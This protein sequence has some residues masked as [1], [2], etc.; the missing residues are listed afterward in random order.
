MQTVMTKSR[1]CWFSI[2]SK[3]RNLG[4]TKLSEISKVYHVTIFELKHT[5]IITQNRKV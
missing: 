5:E 2:S 3:R 1:M 4:K